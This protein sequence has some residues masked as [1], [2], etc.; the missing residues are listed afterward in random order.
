MSTTAASERGTQPAQRIPPLQAGDRLTRDEFERR[1]G[2]MP[3]VRKAELIEGVV[4]MPS[5]VS[6]EG[7]ADPHIRLATLFGV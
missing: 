4:S 6:N 3:Q 5:P 7:H 2:A 1:Y